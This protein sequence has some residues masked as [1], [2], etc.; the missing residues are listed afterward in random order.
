MSLTFVVVPDRSRRT[1]MFIGQS[2]Q[3][4]GGLNRLTG[5]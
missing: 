2:R 4:D 1:G 5:L 3:Q